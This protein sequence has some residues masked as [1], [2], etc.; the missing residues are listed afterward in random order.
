MGKRVSFS[1]HEDRARGTEPDLADLLRQ[2]AAGDE[3]AF[4]RVYDRVAGAVLGLAVRMLRDRAQAEEVAQE[5][6][7]EVWRH[8]T[9]YSPERGNA[10]AWVMTI[11]HR[12]AIDRLR[13]WHAAGDREERA[14]RLEPRRPFDEV[15]ESTLTS[16]ERE[17]VRG[18]LAALTELQR[19][20]IVLAYYNGYTYDEVAH[21][22]RTPTGTVKTRIRDGLIRLRDCMGVAQ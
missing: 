13:S 4:A 9:R 10:L 5:V 19:E 2:V 11:A 22:L 16:L 6:L 20:S 3:A 21:V 7:V 12:R 8:A 14:G 18:C 15:A 1:A 17:R